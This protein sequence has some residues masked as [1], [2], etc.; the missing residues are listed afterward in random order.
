VSV[1]HT[2]GAAFLSLVQP[3]HKKARG[4]LEKRAFNYRDSCDMP[5]QGPIVPESPHMASNKHKASMTL[6][7]HVY[8]SK[9]SESGP[10]NHSSHLGIHYHAHGTRILCHQSAPSG[11]VD[12]PGKVASTSAHMEKGRNRFQN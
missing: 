3:S 4:Q 9:P 5:S 12:G 10:P 1:W 11:A 8:P 2:Y 7:R 6:I